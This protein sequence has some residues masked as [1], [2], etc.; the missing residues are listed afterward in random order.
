MVSSSYDFQTEGKSA[1]RRSVNRRSI[2]GRS[3]TSAA[4]LSSAIETVSSD[5]SVRQVKLSPEDKSKTNKMY[6]DLDKTK[7]WK[8]ST[9]TLV[10][11]QMMKHVIIQDYEQ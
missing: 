11:E 10:E 9:G 1:A 3:S 8:L 4:S 5:V 2:S 7:M 6:A